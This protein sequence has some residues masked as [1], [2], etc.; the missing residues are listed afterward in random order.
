M[1]TVPR[2]ELDH[3]LDEQEGVARNETG[4][5]KRGSA[6]RGSELVGEWGHGVVAYGR[7]RSRDERVSA[8][9]TTRG[10]GCLP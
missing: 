1:D 7:E 9:R 5:N 10:V 4:A 8:W 3:R 6:R 2:A